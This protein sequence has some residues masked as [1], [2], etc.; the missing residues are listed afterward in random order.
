V[1]NLVFVNDGPNQFI[2]LPIKNSELLTNDFCVFGTRFLLS[3][4]FL[5]ILAEPVF[6]DRYR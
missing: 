2:N 5:E 6:V 1:Q 4:S 3:F